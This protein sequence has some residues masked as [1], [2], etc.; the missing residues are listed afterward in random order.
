[1]QQ[2]NSKSGVGV[3]VMRRFLMVRDLPA[4]G[5]EMKMVFAFVLVLVGMDG[6]SLP[7]RPEPDSK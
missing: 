4:V 6:E 3:L 7:K 1:V 2:A 5:V